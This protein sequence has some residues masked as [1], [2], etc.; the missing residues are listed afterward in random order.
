MFPNVVRMAEMPVSMDDVRQNNFMNVFIETR[1]SNRHNRQITK[2][3][4][5]I[6]W[7]ENLENFVHRSL[8][9]SFH[10]LVVTVLFS[11]VCSQTRLG[12][13]SIHI[14]LVR[15]HSAMDHVAKTMANSWQFDNKM[16]HMLVSDRNKGSSCVRMYRKVLMLMPNNKNNHSYHHRRH[17]RRFGDI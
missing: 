1:Q 17:C 11:G 15:G 6:L 3:C 9:S 16:S 4:H 10:T 14:L 7:T 8:V 5:Y 13:K 2:K 12:K